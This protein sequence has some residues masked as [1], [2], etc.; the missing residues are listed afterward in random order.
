[1]DTHPATDD[2][3]TANLRWPYDVWTRWADSRYLNAELCTDPG[4]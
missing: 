3:D 4:L 2:R 1:M